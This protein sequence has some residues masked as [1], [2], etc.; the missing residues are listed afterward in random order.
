[1]GSKV[2]RRCPCGKSRLPDTRCSHAHG[3][4][5]SRGRG[6]PGS[7]DRR[8]ADAGPPPLGGDRR[9]VALGGA[10]G[11]GRR[12]S[13]R[14]HRPPLLGET[15]QGLAFDPPAP[16]PRRRPDRPRLAERG[17]GR[18]PPRRRPDAP[19]PDRADRPALHARALAVPPRRGHA[20]ARA[21]D[22]LYAAAGRGRRAP[23][24]HPRPGRK[25][26]APRMEVERRLLAG[27]P[28]P[29]EVELERMLDEVRTAGLDALAR[30]SE[31]AAAR[32]P[33]VP[34]RGLHRPHGRRRRLPGRRGRGPGLRPR[35]RPGPARGASAVL[36]GGCASRRDGYEAPS[37]HTVNRAPSRTAAGGLG[38]PF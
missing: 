11:A 17:R 26:G 38:A 19:L 14:P 1:M 36:A 25:G 33:L 16:Q 7:S 10:R 9:C 29:C 21:R 32:P 23:S 5:D 30:A 4:P 12:A 27:R 34:S 28:E 22:G 15:A 35:D 8:R 6:W 13:R 37:L 3:L 20:R 18:R 24:I 2:R 31:L